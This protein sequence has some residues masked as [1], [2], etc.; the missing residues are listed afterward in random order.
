[1]RNIAKKIKNCVDTQMEKCTYFILVFFYFLPLFHAY[2]FGY[3]HLKYIEIF[4]SYFPIPSVIQL[5]PGLYFL[6]VI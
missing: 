4:F 2:Y 3:D 5:S 6:L 1:M